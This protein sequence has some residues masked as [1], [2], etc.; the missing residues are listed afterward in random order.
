MNWFKVEYIAQYTMF[1]LSWLCGWDLLDYLSTMR[2]ALLTTSLVAAAH[3]A[4]LS[5]VCTD[6]YAKAA[7]PADGTLPGATIDQASLIV[8][9]AYNYSV[10]GSDNFPDATFDYCNV[11]VSCLFVPDHKPL[12]SMPAVRILAQWTK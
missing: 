11:T 3:G 7:L 12:T 4:S 2:T 9:P 10:N 8:T 5:T 6:A 1:L